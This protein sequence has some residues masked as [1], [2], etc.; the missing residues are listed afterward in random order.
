MATM[1]QSA[2]NWRNTHSQSHG[3]HVFIAHTLTA[4]Q[5]QPRGEPRASTA[6]TFQCVLGLFMFP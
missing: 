4:T 5:L 3:S 2:V 6:V 1:A